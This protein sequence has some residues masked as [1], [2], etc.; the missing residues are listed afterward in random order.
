M[1][2]NAG[3]GK[4]DLGTFL[5][6]GYVIQTEGMTTTPEGSGFSASHTLEYSYSSYAVA[7]FA[8][9][10]G[11]EKEYRELMALSQNWKNLY[12]AQH[13]FIRPRTASGEFLADFDPFAPWVGF[14]E[15]NAW[16]YTFYVP[17]APEELIATMGEDRFVQRLDSIFTVSEKTKFGGEEIDAF[18]G[19]KYLY[20]HGNQPNLHIAYLFNFS[21]HPWLTQK[22]VRKI[23]D[24][25]YGV[26]EVHG[27][28]YGQ[29]EDQGQLGAWYVM[30]AIG[31]FD[32][33]GLVEIDPSFQFGSPLFDDVRIKTGRGNIIDIKT[34]NNAADHYYIQ[35]I[36]LDGKPHG[37]KEISLER[38]LQGGELHF[39]MGP[40]PNKSLYESGT[41]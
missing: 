23:G 39:S 8:K 13:D 22:W 15:G 20:N 34:T 4:L 41:E 30:S 26:D 9:A 18:A 32:V 6:N 37:S 12:D 1:N 21:D 38:L 7:Q 28:G 5:E 11:K 31:L 10:L 35:S 14:Q 3:A 19:I 2:R 33:K 36:E 29:D 25:F 27:Y 40:E 17:H 16:Q 24:G